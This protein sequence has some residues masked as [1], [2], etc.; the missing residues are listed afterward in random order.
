MKAHN[1]RL[2]TLSL[3]I[4]TGPPSALC[5]DAGLD[6]WPT[7]G[8]APNIRWMERTIGGPLSSGKKSATLRGL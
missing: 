3:S 8:V 7:P 6:A 4:A 2:G 5:D 1:S